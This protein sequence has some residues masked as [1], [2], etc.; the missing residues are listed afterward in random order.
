MFNITE[1]ALR[2]P[3]MKQKPLYQIYNKLM[4]IKFKTI[5]KD[6]DEWSLQ[7]EPIVNVIYIVCDRCRHL[8]TDRSHYEVPDNCYRCNRDVPDRMY[9]NKLTLE[10]MQEFK[11]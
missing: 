3:S 6:P 11:T 2:V 8:I 7:V 9:K 5:Y 1:N 10:K 4:P